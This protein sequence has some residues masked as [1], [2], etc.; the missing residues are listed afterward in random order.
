MVRSIKDAAIIRGAGRAGQALAHSPAVDVSI[1]QKK[2]REIGQC[3]RTGLRC[4]DHRRKPHHNGLTTDA[5]ALAF[6]S[7]ITW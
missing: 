7:T 5:T 1:E 6:Q 4:P 3:C 2:K